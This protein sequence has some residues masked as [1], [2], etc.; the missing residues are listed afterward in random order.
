MARVGS[1]NVLLTNVTYANIWAYKYFTLPFSK[2][3][4]PTLLH[5]LLNSS[6]SHCIKGFTGN[7]QEGVSKR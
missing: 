5:V 3:S 4:W 2:L 6:G 1:C 7:S